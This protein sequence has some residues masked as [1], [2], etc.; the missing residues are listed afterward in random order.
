MAGRCWWCV[1]GA[2]LGFC[3]LDLCQLCAEIGSLI[4]YRDGAT[5]GPIAIKL[6]TYLYLS[7]KLFI[8][9][10]DCNI[11]FTTNDN[12]WSYQSRDSFR[13]GAP[14][15]VFLVGEDEDLPLVLG[16]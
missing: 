16:D 7:R 8:W 4:S 5:S 15:G 12:I 3:L 9:F 1:P 10:L 2:F 6:P 14:Q 11:F 13:A